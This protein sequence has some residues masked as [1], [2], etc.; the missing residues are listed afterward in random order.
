MAHGTCGMQ[1]RE[2]FSCFVH[3]GEEP[4]GIDCVEKFKAMQDCFREH[5]DE[6]GE[7]MDII[8]SIILLLLNLFL[9]IADDDDEEN[10]NQ[11][12][13]TQMEPETTT[14]AKETAP[15]T[16]DIPSKKDSKV[17]QS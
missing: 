3:S 7:G 6:Y 11:I 4:K 16:L 15:E 13:Q 10:E 14:I 12:P 2:A 5:P 8:F 1:F 17:D 9:E